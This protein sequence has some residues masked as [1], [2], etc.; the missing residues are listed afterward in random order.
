LES[1]SLDHI[2]S[3]DEIWDQGDIL[4][5]PEFADKP[6]YL[7]LKNAKNPFGILLAY[8]LSVNS[9]EG[10]MIYIKEKFSDEHTVTIFVEGRVNQKSLPSLKDVCNRHLGE[11]RN[12]LLNLRSLLDISRDGRDFLGEMRERIT[13][14]EVPHFLKL[15]FQV[16]PPANIPKKKRR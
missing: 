8:S 11:K 7:L 10:K 2:L 12:I 13:L 3:R 6:P 9:R 14:V 5:R 4:P 1:I 16:S 15:D